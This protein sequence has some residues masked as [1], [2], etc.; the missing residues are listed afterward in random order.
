MSHIHANDPLSPTLANYR[1]LNSTAQAPWLKC[2]GKVEMSLLGKVE[3]SP[4]VPR[5][6][7]LLR[8]LNGMENTNANGAIHDEHRRIRAFGSHSQSS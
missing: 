8:V 1:L 5:K 4:F 7:T 3:M 6:P 2:S